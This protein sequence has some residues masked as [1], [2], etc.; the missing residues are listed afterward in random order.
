ML[1][2][3]NAG[4]QRDLKMKL[5]VSGRLSNLNNANAEYEETFFSF[6]SE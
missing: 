4:N 6:S 2:N 5:K 3:M 1:V